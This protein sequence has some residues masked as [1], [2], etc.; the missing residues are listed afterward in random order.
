SLTSGNDNVAIGSSA[1]ADATTAFNTVAI[2]AGALGNLVSG[3]GNIAIGALAGTN[4]TGAETGNILID[5]SGVV[6][7]S[8]TIRIGSPLASRCFIEGIANVVVANQHLVVIDTTTG[9][10]GSL[11]GADLGARDRKSTRL[12][13]SHV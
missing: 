13:S 3:G 2:G 8:N 5:D 1:M 10:L 12:N 7:E 9:Q 11:A 6:G 4:Y